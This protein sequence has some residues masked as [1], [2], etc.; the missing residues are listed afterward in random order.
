MKR[1]NRGSGLATLSLGFSLAIAGSLLARQQASDPSFEPGPTPTAVPRKT[2]PPF[3]S[4]AGSLADIVKRNASSGEEK[5]RSLGVITNEN[6]KTAAT[7]AAGRTKGGT[8]QVVGVPSNAKNAL[9][10]PTPGEFTDSKGRTE[11]DWRKMAAE[12]RARVTKAD[13][14]VKKLEIESK[15]LENDF[16]AYSDGNYR[17]RVI[18]PAWEQSREDLKKARE[19]SEKAEAALGGLSE[20]AR[21]S[22]AFPGWLRQK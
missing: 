1:F 12:A 10:A 9:P 7:P 14:E 16:Y 20:E 15:R 8:V 3:Q 19:E 4:G 22:G 5:K 18:K 21:K 6:L 13:A 17:D 2:P 11:A